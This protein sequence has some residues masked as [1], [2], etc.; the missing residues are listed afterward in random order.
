MPWIQ[1]W[2]AG[3]T[4]DSMRPATMPKN[5]SVPARPFQNMLSDADFSACAS[6]VSLPIS[7]S[8]LPVSRYTITPIAMP[9]PAAAKP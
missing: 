8:W 7:P 4:P 1:A 5:A 3:I 2:V 6:A 9:T